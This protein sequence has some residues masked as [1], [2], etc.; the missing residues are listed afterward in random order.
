MRVRSFGKGGIRLPHNRGSAPRN[1]TIAFLPTLAVI[2][3]IQHG[4]PP[5]RLLVSQGDHVHEGMIV[6]RAEYPSCANVHSPMPGRVERV[7]S[8][9]LPD[10]RSSEA[11]L[12]R[13]KGSFEKLGKRRERFPWDGLSSPDLQR[14]V[15]ERGVVEM[16][17]QGRALAPL[18]AVA[19]GDGNAVL[20]VNGVF[21]EAP[22]D[23]D[24]SALAECI[25]DIAE[26]IAI[27]VKIAA[28][29]KVIIAISRGDE[30]LAEGLKKSLGH[31]ELDAPVVVTCTAF[32]QRRPRELLSALN[33]AVTLGADGVDDPGRNDPIML[34][35]STIL[36]V[37][38]AVKYNIPI[39][40]RRV[41]VSGSAIKAPGVVRAR[42]GMRIG[43]I[44]ADRGG[45]AEE[46]IAVVVGSVFDGYSVSNLDMPIL[47]TTTAVRVLGK[48]EV[49]GARVTACMGCGNC[50][51]VCPV[52]LDP[53]RLF[54]LRSRGLHSLAESERA[55]ECHGCGCCA[56]V[57]PAGIR[58]PALIRM[59]APR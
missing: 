41:A 9:V 33:R 38:N 57:C 32:P 6:G 30:D 14:I 39:L 55:G 42:I 44:L 4:G 10:G 34:S 46:P 18:L 47:K 12:V 53:E 2:P 7:G 24:R 20:I 28:S 17:G 15:A 43:D 29:K 31:F 19:R 58:L 8:L 23:A 49:D 16:D 25:D 35:P 3:M 45:F 21:D 52:G 51:S 27:L 1:S 22:E 56:V 48:R 40:E 37:L 54:K 59:E 13:L 26:G 5:A 36:A 50:R 11:I